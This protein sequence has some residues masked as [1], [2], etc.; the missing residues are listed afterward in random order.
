[1]ESTRP[2]EGAG[3]TRAALLAA[4]AG[5]LEA[6]GMDAVTLRAVGEHAGVSRQAPYKHFADKVELLSVLAAGY[7]GVLGEEVRRAAA[8]E[9][10]PVRRLEAMCRAYVRYALDAPRRYRLMFGPET[11]GTLHPQ[12]EEQAFQLGMQFV[13]A[14]AEC[15]R[16]GR[17][18]PGEPLPLASLLYATCHGAV[19]LLL[20]GHVK[21]ASGD[22]ARVLARLL[23]ELDRG[24]V[25]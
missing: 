13:G 3:G 22:P 1:M 21:D 17:F 18:T 20:A 14:V 8:G 6:G 23:A 25:G 24:A 2:G 10:D 9:D 15:Q 5:L 19:D 7:F 11:R 12:V 4:A 16:A